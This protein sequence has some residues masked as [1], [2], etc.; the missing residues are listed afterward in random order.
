MT[1]DES[2]RELRDADP[3]LVHFIFRWLRKRYRDHPAADG[4]FGRLSTLCANHR[5]I[6]RHA[7]GGEDD[8]VVGWFEGT[9]RYKDLDSSEFIDIVVEKLE[10]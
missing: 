10:G 7:K 6:T 2:Y 8:P 5:D 1:A 3:V 9:Y 4:V